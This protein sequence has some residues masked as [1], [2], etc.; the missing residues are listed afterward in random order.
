[1]KQFLNLPRKRTAKWQWSSLFVSMFLT[2]LFTGFS[3]VVQS[4][5]C[6]G[7][8][9]IEASRSYDEGTNKTTFTYK[10]TKTG[11]QNGL[12][13]FSMPLQCDPPTPGLD[14]SQ[15]LI[16]AVAQKSNDGINWTG[17][18]SSYGLDNSQSCV[19]GPVFKFDEAATGNVVWFRLIINGNCLRIIPCFNGRWSS[20]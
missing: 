8:F 15:I 14:I 17:A 9:T 18:T 1:M 7:N 6:A 11:A 4:Q 20:N 2:F 16:G 5:S 12:S 13:H 10:I 19:T 3:T